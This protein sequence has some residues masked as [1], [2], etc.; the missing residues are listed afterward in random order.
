MGKDRLLTPG[1]AAATY[2]HSHIHRHILSASLTYLVK[3]RKCL[4]AHRLGNSC[5]AP[6]IGPSEE[7]E[8]MRSRQTQQ[9]KRQSFIERE[10]QVVPQGGHHLLPLLR[11]VV[12][13]CVCVCLFCLLVKMHMC[14][15]CAATEATNFDSSHSSCMII[16]HIHTQ[17]TYSHLIYFLHMHIYTTQVSPSQPV[18]FLLAPG[19]RAM[20]L[21]QLY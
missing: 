15:S 5:K 1:A 9:H 12:C 10:H 13:L 6:C 7:V 4:H 18:P 17:F 19:V 16:V 21:L 2:M 14:R 8:E 11:L 3:E 20:L